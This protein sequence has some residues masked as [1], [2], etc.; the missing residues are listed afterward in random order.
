MRIEDLMGFI[1]TKYN[2]EH[3]IQWTGDNLMDVLDFTGRHERFY[4]W[5]K[6]SRDYENYVASHGNI[7]KLFAIGGH[8]VVPVGSW[9]IKLPNGDRIAAGEGVNFVSNSEVLPETESGP[10]HEFDGDVVI[11]VEEEIPITFHH[12]EDP[13]ET[14]VVDDGNGFHL[15]HKLDENG[16]P[17]LKKQEGRCSKIL[18]QWPVSKAKNLR[19]DFEKELDKFTWKK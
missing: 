4:D 11:D 19:G 17:I 6:T 18:S 1:E 14:E 9:I 16:N 15:R 10:S 12:P 3:F 5:F 13:Y 7:F 8:Y 2:E